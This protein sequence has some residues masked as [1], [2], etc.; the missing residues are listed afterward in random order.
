VKALPRNPKKEPVQSLEQL[1]LKALRVLKAPLVD[2][3][4]F[5]SKMQLLDSDEFPLRA[6][7]R[8]LP[9][10]WNQTDT[11]ALMQY[12]LEAKAA[13]LWAPMAQ[14]VQDRPARPHMAVG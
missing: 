1:L 4:Q 9:W 13:L 10:D 11:L 8:S 12:A 7:K 5:A 2:F 3:D 6:L 14:L